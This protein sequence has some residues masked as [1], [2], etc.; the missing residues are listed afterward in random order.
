MNTLL[1]IGVAAAAVWCL[2]SL[3]GGKVAT[4]PKPTP[5]PVPL[6]KLDT[7]EVKV[8]ID[9]DPVKTQPK[10]PR[11]HKFDVLLELKDC[12]SRCGVDQA[13]VDEICATIAPLLL[14]EDSHE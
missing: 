2:T 11:W 4:P 9:V 6:P 3:G 12:M 13:K 1:L 5:V 8:N 10:P 14:G 7:A